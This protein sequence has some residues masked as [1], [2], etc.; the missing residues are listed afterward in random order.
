MT[1]H[2]FT[3]TEL[4]SII[5]VRYGLNLVRA[6]YDDDDLDAAYALLAENRAFLAPGQPWAKDMTKHGLQSKYAEYTS[7]PP[8]TFVQYRITQPDSKYPMGQI[9]TVTAYAAANDIEQR[10]RHLGYFLAQN[11]TGRGIATDSVSTFVGELKY[12]WGLLSVEYDIFPD[13]TASQRV[14]QKM[15][16]V[17]TDRTVNDYADRPPLQVWHQEL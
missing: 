16:A 1:H 4:P 11:Y 10:Q 3:P 13:N 7:L 8:N 6:T 5:P 12:N 9:G 17:L 15:G 2:E 14:A